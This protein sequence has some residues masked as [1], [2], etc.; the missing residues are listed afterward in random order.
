MASGNTLSSP[1]SS[2]PQ[3]REFSPMTDTTLA[4]HRARDGHRREVWLLFAL[5]F[6]LALPVAMM[7]R[8]LPW[9][10]FGAQR[11]PRPSVISEARSAASAAVGYAF[12]G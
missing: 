4:S 5:I 2:S 7:A 3:H 9:R 10:I 8:L 1:F 11:A 6:A 12:M